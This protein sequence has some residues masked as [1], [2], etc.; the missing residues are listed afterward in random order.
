MKFMFNN[1]VLYLIFQRPTIIE[2]III[3]TNLHSY[4]HFLDILLMHFFFSQ[5]LYFYNNCN[6]LYT[7]KNILSLKYQLLYLLILDECNDEISALRMTMIKHLLIGMMGFHT[8][9]KTFN[10]LNIQGEKQSNSYK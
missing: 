1:F 5:L 7:D 9:K 6:I 3:S 2:I 8:A 10:Y 4:V